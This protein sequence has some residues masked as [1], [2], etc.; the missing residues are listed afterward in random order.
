[1]LDVLSLAVGIAI[2]VGLTFLAVWARRSSVTSLG[3]AATRAALLAVAPDGPPPSLDAPEL[4]AT[5]GGSTHRIVRQIKTQIG[6]NGAMT[7]VVDG[8]SYRHLDDI[9]DPRIRDQVRTILGTV[10]ADVADP[11][12][13]QR[14]E[15]ELRAAGID[16][17]PSSGSTP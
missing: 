13:R 7:I 17:P 11:A 2:G 6:P 10:P 14:V 8:T 16:S 5:P 3:A 4:E 12:N 15:D 1:M 9:P